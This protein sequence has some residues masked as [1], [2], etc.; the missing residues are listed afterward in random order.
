MEG[1][2]WDILNNWLQ[3]ATE[4]DN[5]PFLVELL[6]VYK[7]LPV[8]VEVMKQNNAAK[9]IKQISKSKDESKYL[10]VTVPLFT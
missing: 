1:G 10:R 7:Q 3:E 9:T 6:K 2:M 5:S 8:T 4:A